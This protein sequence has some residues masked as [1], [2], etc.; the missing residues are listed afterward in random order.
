M[1]REDGGLQ[2]C[3]G[4]SLHIKNQDKSPT[5]YLGLYQIEMDGCH[6]AFTCKVP[7]RSPFP[8]PSLHIVGADERTTGASKPLSPQ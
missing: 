5:G 4:P 3:P 2:T 1:T 7:S 6:H 8:E